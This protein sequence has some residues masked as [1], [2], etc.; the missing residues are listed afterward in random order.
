M[1]VANIVELEVAAAPDGLTLLNNRGVVSISGIRN[2][3]RVLLIAG[4]THADGRRGGDFVG[5]IGL[6]ARLAESAFE[7][8][9]ETG[10]VTR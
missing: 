8:P 4:E 7:L 2:R 9:L 5:A 3:L 1:P 10:R 6:Q